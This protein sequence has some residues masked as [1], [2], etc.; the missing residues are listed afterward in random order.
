MLRSLESMANGDAFGE[1]LI[2]E[3]HDVSLT[4]QAAEEAFARLLAERVVPDS[5]QK[6]PW[7]WTDDTAMAIG[8]VEIL[9]NYGSIVGHHHHSHGD[10]D[11]DMQSRGNRW[12]CEG[13]MLQFDALN[14]Q[15]ELAK[16]F[17]ANVTRLG[18]RG[19][20]YAMN[21]MLLAMGNEGEGANHSFWK[22]HSQALFGGTGSFGNGAAMRV[23]P[24]GAFFGPLL[25]SNSHSI[26]GSLSLSLCPIASERLLREAVASSEVTHWHTVGVAGGAVIALAAGYATALSE[27]PTGIT[28]AYPKSNQGLGKDLCH[29]VVPTLVKHKTLLI[30]DP[31]TTSSSSDAGPLRDGDLDIFLEALNA[32]INPSSYTFNEPDGSNEPPV[33]EPLPLSPSHVQAASTRFCPGNKASVL[34]TIPFT[35]WLIATALENRLSL[36]DTLWLGAIGC[37]RTGDTDTILAMAAGTLAPFFSDAELALW[38]SFREPLMVAHLRETLT[39]QS[40]DDEDAEKGDKQ[41]PVV[42]PKLSHDSFYALPWPLG[43]PREGKGLHPL[44][45]LAPS[46]VL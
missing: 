14:A 45:G 26:E 28:G 6:E 43:P 29:Y 34:D 8:L 32:L 18:P 2:N 1:T 11:G 30:K 7:I 41:I 21:T 12:F 5:Y 16:L 19:Y 3:A 27:S 39:Y 42:K 10:D 20:T 24:L 25:L 13:E 23:A 9:L 44:L 35:L 15:N 36:E 33:T 4:S 17:G 38:A 40:S 22:K 37:G 31:I 46:V